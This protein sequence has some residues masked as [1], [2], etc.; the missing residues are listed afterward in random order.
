MLIERQ[1]KDFVSRDLAGIQGWLHDDNVFVTAAIMHT[2]AKHGIAGP[3]FEI[4]VYHG[5]YLSAMHH[6]AKVYGGQ[7][8]P[9]SYGMDVFWFSKEDEA[10]DTF[11][12]LFGS[13]DEIKIEVRNSQESRTDD[14]LA[15]CGSKP[16]F[17]SIDGDHS[18]WPVLHDHAICADALLRG[19]VVSS[20]DFCNWA[21]IGLMDG[22]ARF[23]LTHNRHRLVP[24]A[25]C[26][27]KLYSCHH[28]WHERYR[29]GMIEFCEQ[30][31][32][33]PCASRYLKLAETGYHNANQV[34]FDAPCMIL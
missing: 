30:N 28:E 14:I 34:L 18:S 5:K 6:C 19:G 22:I 8:S 26:L 2:M 4:G 31:S 23:F 11:K 24:F 20:D 27:N 7:Q 13:T 9:K 15:L 16:A 3:N 12:K 29:Q 33:I 21:M 1:T 10:Q 32:D 25:F 17:I